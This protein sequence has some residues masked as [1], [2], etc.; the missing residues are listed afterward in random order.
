M[1]PL[2]RVQLLDSQNDDPSIQKKSKST[3]RYCW[4]LF[5][6]L[7]LV[8]VLQSQLLL[9]SLF[10]PITYLLSN[11]TMAL[12]QHTNEENG[13]N[14]SNNKSSKNNEQQTIEKKDESAKP[15]IISPSKLYY[16]ELISKHNLNKIDL[17]SQHNVILCANDHNDSVSKEQQRQRRQQQ[18]QVIHEWMNRFYGELICNN[19]QLQEQ[20][21]A[22]KRLK[23]FSNL[24]QR[25]YQD[26]YT[27]LFETQCN[28]WDLYHDAQLLLLRLSM[29]Y[30]NIPHVLPYLFLHLPKTAGLCWGEGGGWKKIKKKFSLSRTPFLLLLFFFLFMEI[31]YVYI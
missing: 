17:F 10:P 30:Q 12:P 25:L 16:Y 6:L 20:A 5:G 11:T 29:L 2:K 1:R 13:S 3:R 26:T 22:K 31:M 21:R 27:L 28:T 18:Q 7:I 14:T 15:N 23:L 8:P 9:S 19:T 24:C 4:F